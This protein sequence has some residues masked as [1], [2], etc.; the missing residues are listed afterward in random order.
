MSQNEHLFH[1]FEFGPFS[2]NVR[3]RLLLR[4]EESISLSPKVFDTLVVLVENAGHVLTKDELLNKLWPDSFVEES[5]LTQ[6]ISMLRKA[7]GEDTTNPR[8]IETIPKRGYRFI[9]DV[10]KRNEGGEI[11]LIQNSDSESIALEGEEEETPVEPPQSLIV[12]TRERDLAAE[13]HTPVQ[14]RN[15][16]LYVP[17][18][19]LCLA[20]MA[21]ITIVRVKSLRRTESSGEIRSIA[22]LPFKTIGVQDEKDVLG[23]GMAD[24]II[25]RLSK[26]Q[27]LSTLPTSTIYKYVDNQRDILAIGHDLGVDAVLDGTVQLSEGRV[28]V[29]AQ[30]IHLSD[31]KTLWAG[32]FD[33]EYGNI[34]VVQD[35]ISEKLAE[36]L[37]LQ[38]SESDKGRAS[39]RITE[40]TDAYQSY[41]MGIYFWSRGRED[42]AK[43]IPYFERAV[44]QHRNFAL[45]YAYLAD[46]YYYN[47]ATRG[48]VASYDESVK[49]ARENVEKA[50]ALNEGIAEAHTVVAGIKTLEKDYASAAIE[51]KRA[52]ELNP[53]FARGHNR[54]GV[55]LF[56]MSDLSGAVNELRRGQEL[57]PASR[58]SNAALANMLLFER[59][60]DEAIAYARRA[61]EIDPD[62][63]PGRLSLGEAY[64]LK[65]MYNESIAQF[66]EILKNKTAGIYIQLAKADLAIAYANMGRKAEAQ[67]L[68]QDLLQNG[69]DLKPYI[70]TTV[71][72]ALGDRD[73]ALKWLEKEKLTHFR[74]ATLKYD[75]FLDPLRSD[76]RYNQLLQKP[77]EDDYE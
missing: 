69:K 26:F 28:R 61:V 4:G 67:S 47:A 1:L 71:Y 57:D 54:Y 24:A 30:L 45:A 73:Q 34:F 40:N 33:E 60:Y 62:F 16:K 75:P 8:Y 64:L 70:Y 53:N 42:I 77:V 58:V 36:T 39:A 51:Y 12:S 11:P 50:L 44:E 72:A 17:V 29:T 31:G 9:A 15:W 21:I 46:C 41:L 38:I 22:V 52:L 19:I 2:L 59:N 27:K 7:L 18:I 56:H 20:A 74:M 49:K 23:L 3:E 35:S 76:E 63:A 14:R 10:K 55:F 25:V 65:R 68:L 13:I 32:K 6:N 48:S 5:S 66:N 37:V 43:S